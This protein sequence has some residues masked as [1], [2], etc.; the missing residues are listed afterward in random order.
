M[1][2]MKGGE[3]GG[4]TCLTNISC[5]DF[6]LEF[7]FNG[8]L[9]DIDV[10]YFVC[11]KRLQGFSLNS[12]QMFTTLRRCAEPMSRNNIICPVM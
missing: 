8:F 5:F 1:D 12:G 4:H 6:N 3:G 7:A 10:F 2:G 11:S 9:Y